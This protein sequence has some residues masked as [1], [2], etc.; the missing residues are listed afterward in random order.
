MNCERRVT[1]EISGLV[2]VRY[3][4]L[5]TT[6]LYSVP[7][8]RRVPPCSVS[9]GEVGRGV[10]TGLASD[11]LVLCRRSVIYFRCIR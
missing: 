7:S 1:K 10:V 5:P 11:K 2:K 9:F 4:R 8:P 6:D 3:W